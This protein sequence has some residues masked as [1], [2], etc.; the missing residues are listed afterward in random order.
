MGKRQQVERGDPDHRHAQRLGQRLG[1]GQPDAHP[2]EQSRPDVDGDEA[3]IV[4]IDVG[5]GAAELDRRDERLGVAAAAGDLE[6]GD[7][8]LVPAD[9]DAHLRRRRLDA[10]DQHGR[11]DIVCSACRR[12]EVEG[13]ELLGED[14]PALRPR[15]TRRRDR[16]TAGL[17]GRLRCVDIG[18]IDHFEA[19]LEMFAECRRHD[20]TPLDE[21][22][23]AE[24]GELAEGKVGDLVELFEAVHIGV[25]E[26]PA[27]RCVGLARA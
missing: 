8:A 13:L 17:A 18:Y 27:G 6:Q 7:D 3:E 14:L 20:V 22:D 21:N 19:D 5:L 10:E 23:P 15:S 16:D 26:Q 11:L 4:E 9:G 12:I 2:G 24:L 25:V 1:G